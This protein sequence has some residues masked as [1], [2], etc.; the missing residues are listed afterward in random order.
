MMFRWKIVGVQSEDNLNNDF[1]EVDGEARVGSP[2]SQADD[3]S[4]GGDSNPQDAEVKDEEWEDEEVCSAWGHKKCGFY[5][6]FDRARNIL[7]LKYLHL[8]VCQITTTWNYH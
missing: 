8:V 4:E 3:I 2:K 1:Q 6:V 5:C 7:H